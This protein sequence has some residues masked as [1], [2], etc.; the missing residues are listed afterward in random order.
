MDQIVGTSVASRRFSTALLAGF[1]GLALLL[2]GIGTYGVIA[3]G[4]TQRSFEIGVRI[5]LGAGERSVLTLVLGEGMRLC[6]IGVGLGLLVSV[7]VGRGLRAL[8]VGISP[9]DAPALIL[10]S[11]A[12]FG[13]A[14][15]A[16]LVPARRA[17]AVDPISVLRGG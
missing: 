5:A 1:G 2:A 9:V 17:L 6:A 3:Y 10:A 15:L 12:L 7:V 16:S 14:L 11:S 13:V 4:V 8:L